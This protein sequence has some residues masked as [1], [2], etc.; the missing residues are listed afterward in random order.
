MGGRAAAVTDGCRGV[1]LPGDNRLLLC[2]QHKRTG[3]FGKEKGL[4]S[5]RSV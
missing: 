5:V 4:G 3:R 1:C 2:T